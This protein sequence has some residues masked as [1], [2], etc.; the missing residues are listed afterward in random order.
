MKKLFFS[1]ALLAMAHSAN[2]QHY[3]GNGES[4]YFYCCLEITKTIPGS[5]QYEFDLGNSWNDEV[6]YDESGNKIKFTN[7]LDIINY[8]SK[9]DWEYVESNTYNVNKRYIFKKKVK[10]D[11]EAKEGLFVK[12]DFDKK[13][14]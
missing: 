7:L 11:E 2:A 12:S 14:K 6:L 1:I 5:V 3:K 13:K 9:R 4:Y 8:L 10:K